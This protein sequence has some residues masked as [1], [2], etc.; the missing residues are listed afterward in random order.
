MSFN[1]KR[2][3]GGG[4][5]STA[6]Y[7]LTDRIP[8]WVVDD[9]VMAVW[10]SGKQDHP[11]SFT[12]WDSPEKEAGMALMMSRG[13]SCL[14]MGINLEGEKVYSAL[15]VFVHPRQELLTIKEGA[16]CLI[17]TVK[18]SGSSSISDITILCKLPRLKH[19]RYYPSV[20][21]HAYLVMPY[22]GKKGNPKKLRLD[23]AM[24]YNRHLVVRQ[25]HRWEGK[26]GD[27]ALLPPVFSRDPTIPILLPVGYIGELWLNDFF[28]TPVDAG[29]SRL[30]KARPAITRLTCCCQ[31][32]I[33]NKTLVDWTDEEHVVY[34]PTTPVPKDDA[35]DD[36]GNDPDNDANNDAIND[37][38]NNANNDLADDDKSE[39][40][41][42]SDEDDTPKKE[43]DESGRRVGR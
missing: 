42:E 18:Q 1:N 14:G 38:N 27:L 11:N 24:C 35:A 40:D 12:N 2:G 43:E 34:P 17:A 32:V 23:L 8:T 28:N 26:L 19:G 4:N 36:A 3:C 37:A 10:A 41:D 33:A 20:V 5:M 9:T 22:L 7:S 15:V 39:H 13:S 30:G 25:L 31:E 16:S 6:L 29:G 21:N